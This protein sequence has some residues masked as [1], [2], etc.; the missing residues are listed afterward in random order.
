MYSV[1]FIFYVKQR[2]PLEFLLGDL[3][4]LVASLSQGIYNLHNNFR[5]KISFCCEISKLVYDEQNY[6]FI[7]G[8]SLHCTS[9]FAFLGEPRWTQVWLRTASFEVSTRVGYIGPHNTRTDK[10]SWIMLFINKDLYTLNNISLMFVLMRTIVRGLTSLSSCPVAYFASMSY[11]N[12]KFTDQYMLHH[13]VVQGHCWYI[14]TWI[15]AYKYNCI[16]Y[17]VWDKI[18]YPFR[19]FK[20]A[21]VEVW[22]WIN[23]FIPHYT[24]GNY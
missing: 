10:T 12:R 17:N 5:Q 1:T 2:R 19:N 9:G 11:I 22:E 6:E 24:V 13:E 23:N 4:C 14:W 21:T 15:P 7:V 20:D 3:P 8:V 16:H 18:T